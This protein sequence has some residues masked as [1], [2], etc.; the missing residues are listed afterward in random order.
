MKETKCSTVLFEEGK[1]V[2]CGLESPFVVVSSEES[3][4]T[5]GSRI[6]V[7]SSEIVWKDDTQPPLV[8]TLSTSAGISVFGSGLRF[9]SKILSSGT[10]P[11]FSFGLHPSSGEIVPLRPDSS[12]TTHLSACSLV[13]MSSSCASNCESLPSLK[14][15]SCV[16]QT[17]VGCSLSRSSNHQSGTG[18]LDI[19]LG[20]SLLCQN[21]SF[22]HCTRTSNSATKVQYQHCNSTHSQYSPTTGVTSLS[23]ILCT[24]NEM[25]Y[26]VD[27]SRGGAAISVHKATAT[28]SIEKCFFHKCKVTKIGNDGGAVQYYSAS[29]TGVGLTL[30]DSSFTDCVSTFVDASASAGAL[31]S[32]IRGPSTVSNCFFENC[33]AHG[34]GGAVYL[35]A[36]TS[37]LFNCAFVGCYTNASGGGLLLSTISSLEMKFVQFRAC[38]AKNPTASSDMATVAMSNTILNSISVQFC[39]S[40]SGSP[41]I[42]HHSSG[43]SDGSLIPQVRNV[44]VVSSSVEIVGTTAKVSMTMSEKIKGQMGVLL[45]GANIP[46]LVFLTFGTSTTASTDFDLSPTTILP[47]LESGKTYTIRSWSFPYGQAGVDGVTGSTINPTTASIALSGYHFREGS[48][49]MKVK[50]D[51]QDELTISLT[52]PTLSSLTGTFGMSATDSSKLRYAREYEVKS[53][54]FNSTSLGL[55][56][57]LSFSVPYPEARLTKIAQVNSTDWLTL[58]FEGSGFVAESYIIT[59]S[60]RDEDGLTHETTIT[61]APTSLTALPV[62][63]M[64]L[65]PLDEASLRYGMEYTITSMISTDTFQNVVLDVNSFSTSPEPARITSLTLTGYDELDKTAVFSVEGRVLVENEKYT[66]NVLSSSSAAFCFNFTASSTTSGEGSGILFSADSSK[67]ELKYNTAYTISTVEDQSGDEL[68]LHST[69]TFSTIEEP[70]RLVKLNVAKYDD[71]ETTVFVEL[72]GQ[73]LG[74]TGSY[75]VELS[76]DC[77]VVHTIDFSLTSESKWIGSALLYPSSSCELEYGKTYEVSNFAQTLNSFTSSHFFEPNTLEIEPEPARITSLKLTG[78]DELDKTAF[79]SVEGRVLVENE[80]YRINVLSSSST[81]FSFN[82]TASST[83]RGEGSAILFSA[84]ASTVELAFDMDYTVSNV[85]N[86]NGDELILHS[87]FTFS[88]IVAPGRVMK[89]GDVVAVNDSN[90]TTIGLVG[91][92]MEIGTYSLELVNVVDDTEKPVITASFDSATSGQASASLHPT[93]ELKYGGTYRL[94]KMTTTMENARSVH[95]EPS[96]SFIVTDEPSRLTGI[97]TVVAE[98]SDRRVKIVLT[99]IKMTNG[100]FILTLNNSKTLTATFEADGESGTVS[101]ILFSQDDSK[102]ELEYDTEYTVTGLTDKDN[103]PTFF[104]SSLSFVTPFEPA[105]LVK[106]NDA[107]YDDDETTVFVE[108]IGQKL[109]TTGSYSVELSLDSDVKHTIDFSLTSDSK[110][111]GSALLYPSSSCELEYGK[112]Y[113][114]SNFTHSLNS[115]TSSHFFEPITLEIEAEPSRIE[116]F[117]SA[118]LNKDRLMMTATFTGQA[119]KLE[120]GPVLLRKDTNT[121]ESIGNVRLVDSTH[122][123]ADFMIGDSEPGLVYEQSY[124]LARKDSESSFFVTS[125]VSVRVP[126]PPLLTHVSFA[127]LNKLGISGLV[128][129]EGTD[130]EANKEYQITLEPSFSFTIRISNSTSASSSPLLVGWN[131][132]LPFSTTFKI[133]SITPVDP[134]DGDVLN[135]SLL[136]FNT[137]DR[138]T[139]LF[140]HLDSK[141][142]DLSLFCGTFENP[143]PTIESGWKIVNGLRFARPTLG[144]IDSTTLSS[145]LTVSKG[146]HVLLTHGSNSEP[147]LKIPSS[148]T[149]SNGSGLIV[150]TMASLEIVN[151]DIVLDSPLLSFVLLSAI[152][153]GLLLKDGLITQNRPNSNPDSN[154]DICSWSTGIIQT[155]DCVMNITFNAFTRISSGVINM[156]GGN[157]TLTSSSFSDTSASLDLYPSFNR[158]IHCSDDGHITVFSIPNGGDGS[159]EHPS[160][161]M[162]IEECVLSGKDAPIDSPLF[163]P[164][165]SKTSHSKLD[166]K[167]GHFDVQIE[168][169]TLIPCGLFLEV[170]E[171]SKDKREGQWT[172]FELS[173]SSC[174][175]FTETAIAFKLPLSKLTSLDPNLE[176]RGRLMFGNGQATS[177][178]FLVQA[179]SKER[180]AQSVKENMK[181]WLPLVLVLAAS[182]ILI[183]FI[184][185]VCCRRRNTKKEE[186]KKVK[187]EMDITPEDLDIAKHDEYPNMAS[188]I[189]DPTAHYSSFVDTKTDQSDQTNRIP[190]TP[191]NL[192][193]PGQVNVLKVQTDAYGQEVVKEGYAN[194]GDT[195]YNR[196]HGTGKDTPLDRKKMRHDLVASLKQIYRLRP[197]AL[198]FARLTPFW[199]FLDQF[200][201]LSVRMSDVGETELQ[202]GTGQPG[203]SENLK[204]VVDDGK[205]WE[206]PEQAECKVEV[207]TSKVTGFRL[208]LLLWEITT[209]QIPFGETDGVNAQRQVGIGVLPRM[210]E[211]RPTELV[212]LISDCLSLDPLNRPSLNDIETRLSSI[213][214]PTLVKENEGVHLPHR[215]EQVDHVFPGKPVRGKEPGEAWDVHEAHHTFSLSG[216]IE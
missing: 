153:S 148:T 158:N 119:F 35:I 163:V 202:G 206:P 90:T 94:V 197:S 97:G 175:S 118:V 157:L 73:K 167:A 75:S 215:I 182:A 50:T 15:G 103:K 115:L 179:S 8:D 70:T 77:D 132:S 67:V 102:V 123:E 27:D 177:D 144:I 1:L 210:D 127:P 6:V 190:Q 60:G 124:T 31:I 211:V 114:V 105:R 69:F 101:A 71:D 5:F 128:L 169:K 48:Y 99:G 52:S 54:V 85:T 166:K 137:S 89:I 164:T 199:V 186:T 121:F 4:S 125:D 141:S 130:L 25:T 40:T 143:C 98:D 108:L 29:T 26:A 134:S 91:L 83:T 176:W 63:N 65:Y 183:I 93:V 195:L 38:E 161:W 87:T 37:L 49:Q 53:I 64:S 46:R 42:Y 152:S 51:N 55:P 184:I 43:S 68:I 22:S 198:I 171:V 17:L 131:D 191:S 18:M 213:D 74:S 208:G 30:N 136:S 86:K 149:H 84:D 96:L 126:A 140:I 162:S 76:L 170:F 72:I 185:I 212:D 11:L 192:V 3:A 110:W 104:H 142:T 200:D 107:K 122:C 120:M 41:N 58:S 82:F 39:D 109:G 111:I 44:T 19:N 178:T 133:A 78:Y 117:I 188:T 81:A 88:T 135:K 181:W 147:T 12:T 9:D 95:V 150:V 138:P 196:L 214:S 172:N 36:T 47:T 16:S 201:N 165:L 139:E 187:E 209:G 106:L 80:K 160:A 2:S 204:K 21:S 24:F 113:D 155:I 159:K 33:W 7:S 216:S 112:T 59:L 100:P 116:S 57:P 129:F 205:H 146:M 10:G 79:F 207:D 189:L 168:G 180:L 62:V 145:Q 154:S 45:E 156:K 20:G 14:F 28:L 92:H 66:V 34:R 151:V 61:R 194:A 32:D 203:N 56:T 23:F 193:K 13:N 173:Q 174:A